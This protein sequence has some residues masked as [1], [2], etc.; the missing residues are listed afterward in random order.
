MA[1]KKLFWGFVF[2]FD[3]RIGGVDI[4]P[5]IIGYLFFYQGLLMLKDN[6]TF[7]NNASKYAFPM[8]FISILNIYQFSIPIEQFDI[9]SYSVFLLIF[10][11]FTT[12]ISIM[13]V[14]NICYGIVAE[15]R[16]ANKYEFESK[17]IIAWKLY[18]ITTIL[19]N[20]SIIFAQLMPFIVI[21]VFIASIM[22]YLF[23]LSLMNSASR[24]LNK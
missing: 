15:S 14:Y 6:N 5:D 4:L 12:V 7:F 10:G 21:I 1:Y 23:L 8:I 20:C 3:F 11:L 24:G 19:F 17:S 16:E 13:M 22:S 18:L 9:S 2:L